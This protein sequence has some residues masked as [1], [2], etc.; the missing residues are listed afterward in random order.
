MKIECLICGKKLKA[1]CSHLVRV[2]GITVDDYKLRFGLPLTV[3]ILSE[4]TRDKARKQALELISQGKLATKEAIEASRAAPRRK[5]RRGL[6][7]LTASRENIKKRNIENVRT[8]I[9]GA[10]ERGTHISTRT[11]KTEI[12][13]ATCGAIIIRARDYY[14]EIRRPVCRKCKD[15]KT[16]Q[17]KGKARRKAKKR[18]KKES[19]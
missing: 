1:M 11:D 9:A 19:P 14:G 10:V 7:S 2:H 6:P 8:G 3:G 5:E 15:A 17:A 12:S 13:C 16:Y 18:E 4:S